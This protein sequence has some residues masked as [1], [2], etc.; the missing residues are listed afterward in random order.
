METVFKFLRTSEHRAL[1]GQAEK[2]VYRRGDV[3]LHE[4]ESVGGIFVVQKGRVLI[5]R[6][7]NG[8]E[9]TIAEIGPGQIFGE[10]SFIENQ[11]AGASVVAEEATQALL[12]SHDYIAAI[13]KQNPGFFGRFY[14]SLAAILSRRLRETNAL[15]TSPSPVFP[16][17]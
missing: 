2:R 17:D 8:D 6:E 13:I 7:E 1:L 11:P 10:M 4:G 12:I 14:Q 5:V 9:I 16:Q 15:I 3:L